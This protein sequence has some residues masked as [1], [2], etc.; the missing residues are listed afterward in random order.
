MPT[1]PWSSLAMQFIL[2]S[3]AWRSSFLMFLAL[4]EC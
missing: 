3:L 2:H 4:V 1:L